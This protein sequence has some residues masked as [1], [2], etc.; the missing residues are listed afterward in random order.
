MKATGQ[1]SNI[2]EIVVDASFLYECTLCI[3][4]NRGHVRSKSSGHH[5]SND[6]CNRMNETDGSKVS[7]VLCAIFFRMRA[8]LVEFS[9]C[10]FVVCRL[11]KLLIT[12]ITSGF[13]MSQHNLKKIPVKPSGPG[14]LSPGSSL[15][16]A[17]TSSSV[18][19]APRSKR[20]QVAGGIQ[21]HLKSLERGAPFSMDLVKWLWIMAFF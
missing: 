8:M 1:V 19:S 20:S 21:F 18:N 16:A 15:M 14:A 2:H 9:Q 17:R 13:I 6:L 5:R 7:Y 12:C 10:R 4:G 3:G 11:E